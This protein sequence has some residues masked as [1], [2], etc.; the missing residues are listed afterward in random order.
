MLYLVVLN[1]LR[2]NNLKGITDMESIKDNSSDAK[3][4]SGFVYVMTHSLFSDVV[5]IGCTTADP[6]QYAIELSNNTIGD[7][8]LVFSLECD[9][10]CEVK[11]Q[12]REQLKAQKYVEEF[13][14]VSSKVVASLAKREA[15]KIPVLTC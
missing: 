2:P 11:K 7:Y 15:F 9:S 4:F 10:P 12:L 6:N 1:K 8:T 14:Q 5:R 3:T 13:Y